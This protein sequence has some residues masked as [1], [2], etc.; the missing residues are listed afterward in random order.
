MVATTGDADAARL[1]AVRDDAPVRRVVVAR[2]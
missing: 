2:R 1:L